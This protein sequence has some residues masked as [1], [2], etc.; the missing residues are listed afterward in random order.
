MHLT[1]LK[2]KNNKRNKKKEKKK[3]CS[4]AIVIFLKLILEVTWD[5]D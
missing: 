2:R 3:K 5:W 1:K 4:K